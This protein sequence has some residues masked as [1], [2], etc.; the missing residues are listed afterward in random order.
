MQLT[1][2]KIIKGGQGLGRLADGQVVMVGRVLPGE[3]VR[4]SLQRSHR[5]YQEAELLEVLAPSPRRIR[6][7]CPVYDV[8]GGCNFQHVEYGEQVRLKHAILEET[9]FR[10]GLCPRED[11]A[12]LMGPPLASP[13]ALGYR[14]RV[15]LQVKEG[16]VGFFSR[17]SHA[18]VPVSRCLLARET[19]N[20]VLVELRGQAR[21]QSLLAAASALEL[22]EDLAMG[23][24]VLLLHLSRKARPAEQKSAAL[25]CQE[26]PQLKAV[27]F[28]APGQ[29]LGPCLTADGEKIPAEL[30]LTIPLPVS[31]C[32]KAL[33]LSLE[34]GGFCQVHPAQNERCIRLL[35]DWAG[36]TGP[37]KALDLFCGMGNFSLPLALQ[38]WEIT[39]MDLKRATIRSALRNARVAGLEQRCCFSQE[40]AGTAARRLLNEEAAFDLILLDP[41]RSG[42][43]TLIPLLPQLAARQLIYISCDPATLARDLTGLARAGYRLAEARMV[44]MFPQTG[45]QESMVRLE[46]E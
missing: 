10:A 45:H 42:C 3:V 16:V 30:L 21:F 14:Q 11:L 24:A 33:D 7:A 34:P 9:I 4:V 35:L 44:D 39:G 46:R 19:L 18:I 13:S 25:L 41:P 23:Q 22:L 37:G 2:E 40:D 17:S 36:E 5:R 26:L 38:G 15:R 31:L 32:G 28:A 6:P 43:A 29:A 8:C 12:A 27:I 20:Q 1:I